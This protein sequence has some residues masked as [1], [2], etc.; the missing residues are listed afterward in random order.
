MRNKVINNRGSLKQ[1]VIEKVSVLVN[2]DFLTT[3]IIIK[4]T[5][6]QHVNTFTL[7]GSKL[8]VMVLRAQRPLATIAQFFHFVAEEKKKDDKKTKAFYDWA[9]TGIPVKKK[10]R[11]TIFTSHERSR[12][13]AVTR[14]I[15]FL[16]GIS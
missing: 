7:I 16:P 12:S 6:D 14:Q 10:K 2:I 1:T 13:H 15:L 4:I 8:V 11:K 5:R 9:T 3:S